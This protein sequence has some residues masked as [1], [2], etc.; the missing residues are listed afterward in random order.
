MKECQLYINSGTYKEYM[1]GFK[2][3]SPDE[4]E[5]ERY[6]QITYGVNN[7]IY[8]VEDIRNKHSDKKIDF[9]YLNNGTLFIY[10]EKTKFYCIWLN[11]WNNFKEKTKNKAQ[12]KLNDYLNA[13]VQA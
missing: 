13:L 7:F 12:K 9:K 2:T 8:N 1:N 4:Y 10:I 11:G 5:K 3:T 6:S